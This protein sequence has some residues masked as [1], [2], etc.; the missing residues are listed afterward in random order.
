MFIQIVEKNRITNLDNMIKLRDLLKENTY[1]EYPVAGD[2]V[3]GRS[4]LDNIDNTSS[5]AASLY[6]YKVLDGIRE[7][8]MSDFEVSGKH[9]SVQ[10]TNRIQQLAREISESKTIAPLIVVVDK[11][12]SY[13]LEGATRLSALKV[14]GAKSF[15]A[16]VVIDYD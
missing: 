9:Y 10:G 13:V 1:K 2:V 8:P 11:K 12:G 6:R 14:I 3:D 7:V 4:V 16:L 15:P 5:I